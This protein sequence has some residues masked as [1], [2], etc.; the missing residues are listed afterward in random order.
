MHRR[1]EQVDEHDD[2][3]KDFDTAE[4]ELDATHK[5]DVQMVRSCVVEHVHN[6]HLRRRA[7]VPAHKK[8]M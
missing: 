7:I 3:S 1:D 5:H 6:G 8:L 4:V 2:A